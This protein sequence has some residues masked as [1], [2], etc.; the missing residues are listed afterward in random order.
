[1]SRTITYIGHEFG[2]LIVVAFVG[3][4]K[5]GEDR[6][7]ERHWRCDCSCGGSVIATTYALKSR[8]R[9]HCD[10]CSPEKPDNFM[11]RYQEHLATFNDEERQQLSAILNGD[12][13]PRRVAEAVDL[14]MRARSRES[15][16]KAIDLI[17]HSRRNAA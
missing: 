6:K 8:R 14:I 12:E 17:M 16:A 2:E 13:S 1:M 11:E 9:W 7:S 15:L 5:D 3:S 10:N 4:W